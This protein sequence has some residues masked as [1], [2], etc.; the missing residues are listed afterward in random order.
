M[1]FLIKQCICIKDGC[2]RG[3][4]S[5]KEYLRCLFGF[6][7]GPLVVCILGFGLGRWAYVEGGRGGARSFGFTNS[8][9]TVHKFMLALFWFIEYNNNS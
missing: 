1:I 2:V 6:C 9:A 8:I 5:C 3:E 4:R 7:W